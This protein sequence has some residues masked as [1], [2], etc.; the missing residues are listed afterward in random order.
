MGIWSHES[1]IV[2]SQIRKPLQ[3][4][5]TP[6]SASKFVL[7]TPKTAR[8]IRRA[9]NLYQQNHKQ[10]VL[11]KILKANI[12]LAAQVAIQTHIIKDL[13]QAFKLEKK[14]RQ[15]GKALNLVGEEDSGPQFFSPG[16]IQRARDLQE[17]KE[18]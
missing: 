1:E 5:S 6:T 8:A 14:K 16:C 7:E 4:P 18:A 13:N 11:D 2:L 3:E 17:E 10:P 12:Q 9:H 15:R